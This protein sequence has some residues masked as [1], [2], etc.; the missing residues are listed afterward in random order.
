[1]R[2]ATFRRRHTMG[3]AFIFRQTIAQSC[4]LGSK[5]AARVSDPAARLTRPPQSLGLLIGG[6]TRPTNL[7][8]IMPHRRRTPRRR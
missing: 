6:P 2:P 1:M 3:G 7:R 5:C 8:P 4:H